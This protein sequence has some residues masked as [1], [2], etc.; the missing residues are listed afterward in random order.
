MDLLDIL[1]FKK[2]TLDSLNSESKDAR[3]AKLAFV[4]EVADRALQVSTWP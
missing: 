3:E 1:A 2:H 4:F